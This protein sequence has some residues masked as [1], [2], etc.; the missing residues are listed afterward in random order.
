MTTT[1]D[2]DQK[3][4]EVSQFGE[5]KY[6]DPSVFM[7]YKNLDEAIAAYQYT[8]QA[9]ALARMLSRENVFLSGPAGSGKSHLVKKYI[10]MMG[11]QFGDNVK[12]A[13]T[14]TTGVAASLIGGVTI[15]SWSGL[16]I[17][18]EVKRVP[19]NVADT[20]VLIIDEISMLQAYYLDL[21]DEVCRRAKRNSDPF[22]GIQVIFMGDFL[23]L[24]PVP[25][26]SLTS[27]FDQ[28]YAFFAESWKAADIKHC[29]LDK[30]MRAKEPKLQR[31][32]KDLEQ[33]TVNQQTVD[34]LKRRRSTIVQMDPEKTYTQLYTTNKK[35]DEINAKELYKNPNPE[36]VY[37]SNIVQVT[38]DRKLFEEMKK[39][40]NQPESVSLKEGAKVMVTKNGTYFTVSLRGLTKI[41]ETF[42]PN[43]SIG[44]V[45]K[46]LTSADTRDYDLRGSVLVRLNDGNII[47]VNITDDSVSKYRTVGK[48]KDNKPVSEKV[49]V[50]S[51]S[52]MPLKLA[53]AISVHK[54]QGQTLS[55][56]YCDLSKCFTPG[57][58][59][60]ALSRVGSIDD[61]IV[62]DFNKK[63]FM[64]DPTS[65]KISKSLKNSAKKLR[66]EFLEN[67]DD[68]NMIL[69]VPYSRFVFWSDKM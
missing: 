61:L 13:V 54:S 31:I 2:T 49:Q 29:F 48:S 24:P 8:S 41:G 60:V 9:E 35:V 4:V 28:R 16:R 26:R 6:V 63:T 34:I 22:G 69:E 58:G 27:E 39:T 55:A 33:G 25:N 50:L 37:K 17:D 51:V 40:V 42:A 19:Q 59:Y 56:A 30:A 14:G 65:M 64:M 36:K 3:E 23:Q 15:H 67:K 20:D 66:E 44:E 5:E 52:Y 43:G 11:E 18:H 53:Y 1:N 68:Y 21:V 57:L 32:L 7:G 62:E 10:E 12:I 45:V 46:I 47:S 38:P